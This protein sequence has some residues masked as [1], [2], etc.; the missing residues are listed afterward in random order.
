MKPTPTRTLNPLPFDDL[1]PHRFED[2]IRQLAYEPHETP[3]TGRSNSFNVLHRPRQEVREF[4]R[5]LRYV[6]EA[7]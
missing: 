6:A 2:L 4:L 7:S 3:E 1:E 5:S